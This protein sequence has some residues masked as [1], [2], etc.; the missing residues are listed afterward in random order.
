MRSSPA[1]AGRLTASRPVPWP[2]YAHFG[3][4]DGIARLACRRVGAE[5]WPR[6]DLPLGD[7]GASPGTTARPISIEPEPEA[8]A[9]H[10]CYKSRCATKRAS[11]LRR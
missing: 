4:L 1:S 7:D 10:L 5:A 2:E 3:G 9:R 11:A 8:T 6:R